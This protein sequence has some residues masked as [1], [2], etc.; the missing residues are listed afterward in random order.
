MV[1]LD[2]NDVE[3]LKKLSI[4]N[5]IFII[6]CNQNTRDYNY[7]IL[8]KCAEVELR[9]RVKNVGCDFDDLLHFD[10]KVIKTRGKDINDYLISPKVNMQKLMEIY[11]MHVYGTTFPD[12]GLLFSEKHLCNELDF[13]SPFFSNILKKEIANLYARIAVSETKEQ[14][15]NLI[16]FKNMLEASMDKRE[17]DK[18]KAVKDN[19]IGLHFHNDAMLQLD[20]VVSDY[21]EFLANCSDEEMYKVLNSQSGQLKLQFFE[22]LNEYLFDSDF[23]Q[24]LCA[25]SFIHKDARKLRDQKSKLI[26]Q[27]ENAYEVDYE[28]AMMQKALQRIN[29]NNNE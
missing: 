28:T 17:Q 2:F 11:F 9:K 24:Y 20:S 25:L 15:E 8:R 19:F 5:L 12:N 6:L 27:V 22:F 13:M 1:L 26:S 3:N 29:K 18:Q 4:S 23:S 10:D 21:H 7:D 14:K 16:L